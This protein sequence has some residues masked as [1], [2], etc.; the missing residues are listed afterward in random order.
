MS[1]FLKIVNIFDAKL[2][3]SERV[4]KWQENATPSEG[5]EKCRSDGIT[6][7]GSISRKCTGRGIRTPSEGVGEWRESATPPEGVEKCRSDGITAVGSVC[8]KCTGHG[9]LTP[10]EG[11]WK[12]QKNATPYE[13][14]S[15]TGPPQRHRIPGFAAVAETKPKYAGI[16]N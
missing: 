13:G 15:E 1:N 16:L 12:W 3:P 14:C 8:R 10:S 6:A 4:G 9:I 7:V 5:V 11:V 2:T